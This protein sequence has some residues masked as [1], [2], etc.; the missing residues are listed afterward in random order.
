MNF[1]L[2]R[3]YE[4]KGTRGE[5]LDSEGNHVCL[6]IERPQTGEFP[7]IP[8]GAYTLSRYN[9]PKHGPNTWQYDDVPGRTNIQIH[10]A[11]WPHELEGCQAPGML[12]ATGVDG[13]PGVGQS[14][15]AYIKFMEMTKD[16]SHLTI[17][18]KTK[19]T[20]EIG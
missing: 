9:S 7:C 15:V 18:I 6:M 12:R 2:I 14:R 10:I 4:E 13:E 16:Y 11:N 20:P 8:E 17:E 1:T 3:T 5:L 19:E